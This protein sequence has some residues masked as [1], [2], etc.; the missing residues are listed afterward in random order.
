MPMGAVGSRAIAFRWKPSP[1]GGCA[2]K[3]NSCGEILRGATTPSQSQWLG[4]WECIKH[5]ARVCTHQKTPDWIPASS[6]KWRVLYPCL[7]VSPDLCSICSQR[8]GFCLEKLWRNM[9][10]V[11][12]PGTE[13]H[14]TGLFKF[15]YLLPL[16]MHFHK[17]AAP[18]STKTV[19][20]YTNSH[21]WV[22]AHTETCGLICHGFLIAAIMVN[23]KTHWVQYSVLLPG[24]KEVNKHGSMPAF[25]SLWSTGGDRHYVRLSQI[26]I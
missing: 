5:T 15:V 18:S 3:D 8:L 1:G 6:A 19:I 13:A 21:S 12:H 23:L 11:Q 2:W 16:L 25:T 22:V 9:P 7:F 24:S 10:D 17:G 4:C 26:I 20:N 14:E